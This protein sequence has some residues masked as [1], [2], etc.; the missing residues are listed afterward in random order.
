MEETLQHEKTTQRTGLQTTGPGSHHPKGPKAT[1]ALTFKP[2]HSSEADQGPFFISMAETA[3]NDRCDFSVVG[4]AV[5]CF[6]QE[7]AEI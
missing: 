5:R 6:F 3:L 4:E 2:D 7:N 1:N